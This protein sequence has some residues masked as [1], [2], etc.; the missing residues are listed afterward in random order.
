MKIKWQLV[1]YA[2]ILKRWQVSSFLFNLVCNFQENGTFYQWY[3][4][5]LIHFIGYIQPQLFTWNQNMNILILVKVL[6]TYF[7]QADLIIFVE[8][9]T[10]KLMM[11]F[12]KHKIN[13]SR[14][15]PFI[16]TFYGLLASDHSACKAS[17]NTKRLQLPGP[18][19]PKTEL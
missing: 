2:Q 11:W 12:I 3:Y 18:C 19:S 17:A 13:A 15:P 5:H 1:T 7:S 8:S 4:G 6:S 16:D 9:L 10:H 14:C